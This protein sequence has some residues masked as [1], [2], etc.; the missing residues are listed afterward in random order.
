LARDKSRE[1][2]NI[3]R[4]IKHKPRISTITSAHEPSSDTNK[5]KPVHHLQGPATKKF[6]A[7]DIKWLH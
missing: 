6:V 2:T 1:Q 3:Y 4:V 5:T 7:I